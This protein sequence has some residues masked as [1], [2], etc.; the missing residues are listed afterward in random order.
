MVISMRHT[1]MK[2]TRLASAALLAT[3][4]VGLAACDPASSASDQPA[5][6]AA[7]SQQSGDGGSG[8]GGQ[9]ST[10]ES[11]TEMTLTKTGGMAG[12]NLTLEVAADGAWT[13]D[14]AKGEPKTGNLSEEE[15]GTLAEL[16]SD[17]DLAVTD[18]PD[19]PGAQCNDMFNYVLTVGE[20]EMRTDS[21]GAAPNQVF[22]DIVDLLSQ[23]TGI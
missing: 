4:V 16:S 20:Q 13:L 15:T 10:R 14:E 8:D 22:T 7:S 2:I 5:D 11:G 12:L 21:C 23:A 19:K 18:R 3:V 6:V 9:E 1:A 17:P